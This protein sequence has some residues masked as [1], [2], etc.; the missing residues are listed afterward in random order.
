MANIETGIQGSIIDARQERIESVVTEIHSR[1]ER[2][3]TTLSERHD[4]IL[5]NL[6]E[7]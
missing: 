7:I 6:S 2:I 3:E 4:E 1:Q 5:Q